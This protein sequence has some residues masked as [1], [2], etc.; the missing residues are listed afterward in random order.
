VSEVT[1]TINK[2]DYSVACEDGQEPHL[3]K[4]V[5]M[6]DEKVEELIGA[7]GQIGDAR[8]LV[9][10]G[11]LLADDLSEAESKL[12]AAPAPTEPVAAPEPAMDL[13]AISELADAVNEAASRLE[14]LAGR[15]E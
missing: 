12:D 15:I 11:L 8:L 10:A 9:M 14:N 4:L 3:R 5:R 7:M 13:S 6:L 1:F 2:R